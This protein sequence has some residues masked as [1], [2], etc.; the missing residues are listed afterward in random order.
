[1]DIFSHVVFGAL[2]Y[3]LFLR[4]ISYEYFFLALFF[5][6]L[7]DLD[8]F[9]MLL[10]G[11]F[12]STY[13]D[14]RAGSH[15]YVIGVILSFIISLVYSPL[16]RKPFFIVWIV[17]SFFYGIHVSQDMLTTTKIPYLYPL[18][19]KEKGF[20]VEKA[21]SLFTM[22]CS[23]I[24]F[25]LLI[26]FY[27]NSVD[28]NYYRI[29]VDFYTS[30]FLIYYLYRIISKILVSTKLN[31][32]QQ[33]L[34]GVLPFYYLIFDKEIEDK[35]IS[36]SLIKKAHFRIAKEILKYEVFLNLEEI[37]LFE[38]ATKLSK[39]NY[40]FAKWTTLPLFIR[41]DGVF[42]VK[43]FFLEIMTRKKTLH[44]QYDFD[45]ST[46]QLISFSQKRSKIQIL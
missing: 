40:Y 18:S 45:Y 15:S 36:L 10:K 32:N 37:T 12:K 22:I 23:T 17:G 8:I 41:R 34:P 6:I 2:I 5:V 13:L 26:I 44:V 42:S 19:K 24:F 33:Y 43:L 3:L 11:K 28:L 38:K 4:N 16:T 7:P 31:G 25:I 20:Y 9:L 27:Y 39:S 30:F 14:H 1:M 29:L 46:Q 21:G 35:K